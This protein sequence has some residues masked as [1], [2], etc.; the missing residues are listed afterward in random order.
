MFLI[1]SP[2]ARKGELWNL[3]KQHYGPNGDPLILVAQGSSKSFNP[4]LPQSVVDR[5]YE[6]DAVAAAAEY[7]GE[8]RI[9]IQQLFIRE[10]VL[11]CVAPCVYERSRQH[12]EWYHA[13]CDP[14]GGSSDSMT[15]AIGHL[16]ITTGVMIVDAIREAKPPFSPEAA[17]FQHQGSPHTGTNASSLDISQFESDYPGK[18]N[19]TDVMLRVW[20]HL[21]AAA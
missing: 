12:Y 21:A 15:L 14:S 16:D 19:S 1:S 2:Y 18:L 10:A 4:T 11:A 3:F 5:A 9:D 6:R 17:S 8:F 13:F 20:Q 7:G